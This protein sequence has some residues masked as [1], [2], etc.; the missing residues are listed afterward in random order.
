MLEKKRGRG[1]EGEG[2]GDTSN[3]ISDEVVK[4]TDTETRE[5]FT[6]RTD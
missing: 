2:E 5:L 6:W 4:S 3:K 1:R